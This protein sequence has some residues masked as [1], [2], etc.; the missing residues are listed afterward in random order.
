MED[1][2]QNLKAHLLESG[3]QEHLPVS[4][5]DAQLRAASS[6]HRALDQVA[7]AASMPAEHHGHHLSSGIVVGAGGM[8]P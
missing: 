2:Y 1:N 4:T 3:A 7:K 8:V 5:K 6:L